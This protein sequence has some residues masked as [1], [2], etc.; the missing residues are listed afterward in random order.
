MI[1]PMDTGNQEQPKSAYTLIADNAQEMAESY[2][3]E[4]I[5][6]WAGDLKDAL[7]TY[8]E[9]Y[10][11]VAAAYI[12]LAANEATRELEQGAPEES[13]SA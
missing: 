10:R 6:H 9:G 1:D 12:A 4:E 5:L 13:M 2:A 8:A 3:K 7:R 11:Q